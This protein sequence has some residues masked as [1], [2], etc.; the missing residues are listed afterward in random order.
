MLLH[1][2][3]IYPKFDVRLADQLIEAIGVEE[4]SDEDRD[5]KYWDEKHPVRSLW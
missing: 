5:Q 2:E 4:I 1:L 3:A